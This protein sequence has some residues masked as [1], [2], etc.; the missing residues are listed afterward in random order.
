MLLGN[1]KD[2][3]SQSGHI[4]FLVVKNGNYSPISWQ[5]KKIPHVVKSTFAAE[6]LALQEVAENCYIL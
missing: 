1:L 6:T 2:G 4:I 3:A 5:S